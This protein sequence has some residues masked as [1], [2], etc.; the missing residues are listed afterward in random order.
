MLRQK[1]EVELPGIARRCLEAYRRLRERGHF[2][3]PKSCLA[4]EERIVATVDPLAA[5][6]Q[7]RC[8]IGDGK[9]CSCTAL[10]SAYQDW[11][12]RTGGRMPGSRLRGVYASQ[13]LVELAPA[14]DRAK[15]VRVERV[16]RDVDAFDAVTHQL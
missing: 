11:C 1:L 8:E 6:I 13:N 7:Q 15:L 9:E 14:R 5:F 16:Q 12:K 3:Q 10:H 4:L 2:I